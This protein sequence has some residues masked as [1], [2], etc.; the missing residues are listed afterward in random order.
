MVFRANN[1]RLWCRDISRDKVRWSLKTRRALMSAGCQSLVGFFRREIVIESILCSLVQIQCIFLKGQ[2][3]SI[4]ERPKLSSNSSQ[5]RKALDRKRK[6]CDVNN[7]HDSSRQAFGLSLVDL[8]SFSSSRSWD[9]AVAMAYQNKPLSLV[10]RRLECFS[11]NL[12]IIHMCLA[13]DIVNL[14]S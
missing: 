10:K 5:K 8:V 13:L 2:V 1:V 6:R 3:F 11:N 14:S 7:M 4:E 9:A 12:N